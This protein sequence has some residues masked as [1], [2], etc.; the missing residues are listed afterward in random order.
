MM[1]GIE[2]GNESETQGW[3]RLIAGV[4]LSVLIT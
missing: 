2:N 3:V 1:V 4:S